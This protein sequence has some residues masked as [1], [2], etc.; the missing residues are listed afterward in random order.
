MYKTPQY[1]GHIPLNMFQK[2]LLAGGSAAVAITNPRRGD[3]VA[4]M[5]EVTALPFILKNIHTRMS[6]DIE[7][8]KILLKKPRINEVTINRNKL[9]SLKD[10]TFG[11]EY[12]RFLE[13]LKTSP[14]NRPPVQYIDDPELLYVMQ[15]YRETHDFTH[16][17]L[18]M[19]PNMLG[20]VTVKY[21]EAIQLGLPMCISA[22]IFGAARLGPKHRQIFTTQY[23]PWIVETAIKCRLFIALDWESRF[24]H[25]I[26][27]I[28]KELGIQPFHK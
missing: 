17:I 22:A 8:K 27:D 20:E 2:V 24:H 11:R 12:E 14:D 3:M 15:R 7:G 4:A 28:Q 19:K 18:R 13:K 9:H 25:S 5:G 16:T 21:F 26:D 23:L 10:G 1:V 6:K